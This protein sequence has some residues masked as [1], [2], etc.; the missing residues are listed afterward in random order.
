ME[1]IGPS[2]IYPPADYEMILKIKA[3]ENFVG[4]I[5]EKTPASFVIINGFVA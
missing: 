4:F 5:Q 2:R 3:N 1:R